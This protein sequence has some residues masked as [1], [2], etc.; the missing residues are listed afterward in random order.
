MIATSAARRIGTPTDVAD[1][2]AML[3]GS[4]G[5]FITGAD[6]LIHGGVIAAMR[7]AEAATIKH[8]S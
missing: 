1:A 5:T 8:A 7:S 3:L 2:A 4:D 6:L